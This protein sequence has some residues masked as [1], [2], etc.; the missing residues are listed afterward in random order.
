[1]L[2]I[3]NPFSDIK[4]DVETAAMSSRVPE[5]DQPLIGSTKGSGWV[6]TARRSECVTMQRD[7]FS[8]D[9]RSMQAGSG[10]LHIT[11]PSRSIAGLHVPILGTPQVSLYLVVQLDQ[12]QISHPVLSRTERSRRRNSKIRSS[13]FSSVQHEFGIWVGRYP[14]FRVRRPAGSRC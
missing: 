12:S 13:C 2:P 9:S 8:V 7:S 4:P 14:L 11:W 10:Q 1:M 5:A 3:T 6:T